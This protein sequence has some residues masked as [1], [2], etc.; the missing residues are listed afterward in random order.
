MLFSNILPIF[1]FGITKERL[2]LKNYQ[3]R[4]VFTTNKDRN[5][6]PAL[7]LAVTKFQKRSFQ[8]IFSKTYIFG[9]TVSFKKSCGEIKF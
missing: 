3:Q 8:I 1:F 2:W 9:N 4:N 7:K 5:E 6:K